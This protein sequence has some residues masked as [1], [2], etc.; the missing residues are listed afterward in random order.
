MA[1]VRRRTAIGISS[2]LQ[3]LRRDHHLD[4]LGLL[5]P[6]PVLMTARVMAGLAPGDRLE[7]VGD[8]PDMLRDIPAWCAESGN[9]LLEVRRVGDTIRCRLERAALPPL[10]AA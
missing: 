8:D 10:G 9:R 5:C 7:V 6:V 3:P 4:V 2:I 1:R